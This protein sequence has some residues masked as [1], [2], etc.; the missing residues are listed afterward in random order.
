MNSYPAKF[1]TDKYASVLFVTP[2]QT[3]TLLSE[4]RQL[5]LLIRHGITDWNVQTKL[6]GRVDVP[7]NEK[8]K[9]QAYYCGLGIKK[10]VGD[11]KY[12]KGVF[13]SPLSRAYDTAKRIT[14]ELKMGEPT[15][16][17]NLMERDYGTVT[18]M[19]FD[20][21]RELYKKHGGYPGD[22][23]SSD[24][25]AIRMKRTVKTITD[26]PGDG[27]SIIVTH[28][29]LLNSFFSYITCG[30]AGSG[31]N[32]TANC[33]VEIVAA[34]EKDVIPIAFNLGGDELKVFIDEVNQKMK[35]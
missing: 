24:E 4:G 22:M 1:F 33:T 12:V 31:G 5:I 21:R 20:E 7:L 9:E 25:A 8:G 16:L 6:Q 17:E 30:R 32:I 15:V 35:K 13:S 29:G 11:R 2:A 28:G 18:G 34:G 27:I 10:A 14:Y 26:L 19:T 3:A 23:E